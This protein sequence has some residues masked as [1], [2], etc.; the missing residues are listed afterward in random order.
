MILKDDMLLLVLALLGDPDKRSGPLFEEELYIFT[1]NAIGSLS[2]IDDMNLNKV[3]IS[4]STDTCY[5]L[6]CY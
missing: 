3:K 2:N 5:N 4:I 6:Y 1:L